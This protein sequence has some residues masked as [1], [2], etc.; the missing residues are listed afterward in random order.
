[1]LGEDDIV[2]L[3]SLESNYSKDTD[4]ETEQTYEA[5]PWQ[6]GAAVALDDGIDNNI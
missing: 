2:M 4:S 5:A 3:Q 1:M 6:Y